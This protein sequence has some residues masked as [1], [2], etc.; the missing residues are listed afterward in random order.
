[1]KITIYQ[2]INPTFRVDSEKKLYKIG[3]YKIVYSYNTIAVE[4]SI[5][6][7]LENIFLQFNSGRKPEGYNGHSLSVSDI[8]EVDNNLYICDNVGWKQ[9]EW[10]KD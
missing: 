10:M 4:D 3:D 2:A 8:V 1:M 7:L 6:D 5:E 9:I